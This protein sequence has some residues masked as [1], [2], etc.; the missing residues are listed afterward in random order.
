MNQHPVTGQ[1]EIRHPKSEIACPPK[2][3]LY[4]RIVRRREDGYHELETVF[5]SV[6]GGDTLRAEPAEEL[7][8]RCSEPGIPTDH[9]NLVMKAAFA[10]RERFPEAASRGALL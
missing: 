8:L 5:Q 4:L 3:N 9:T 2:L 7:T 6:G 10:L 1:S